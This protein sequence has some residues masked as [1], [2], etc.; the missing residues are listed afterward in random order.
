M[1][2]DG[3]RVF[4]GGPWAGLNICHPHPSPSS[5]PTGSHTRATAM[6]LA[7]LFGPWECLQDLCWQWLSTVQPWVSFILNNFAQQYTTIS[8]LSKLSAH[9]VVAKRF[10]NI[11]SRVKLLLYLKCFRFT[12]P[13]INDY[14]W[15]F[16][17]IKYDLLYTVECLSGNN[18]S[19]VRKSLSPK[20]EPI[21]N[22]TYFT[23]GWED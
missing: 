10:T 12:G 14:K 6:M 4:R 19:N 7:T 18:H 15:G 22:P 16:N 2:F 11:F 13:C 9:K 23:A 17:M 5:Q 3:W 20:L 8:H 21:V 1:F